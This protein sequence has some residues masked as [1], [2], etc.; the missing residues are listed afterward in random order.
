MFLTDEG[1]TKFIRTITRLCALIV[2][3]DEVILLKVTNPGTD[4]D[5]KKVGELEREVVAVNVEAL[6]VKV[7]GIIIS[8]IIRPV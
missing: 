2:V 1:F 4:P 6:M 5:T 8:I 7:E 3:F